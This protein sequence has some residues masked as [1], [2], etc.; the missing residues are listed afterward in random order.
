M[1][2]YPDHATLVIEI[3]M[4]KTPKTVLDFL[5]VAFCIF[6]IVKGFERMKRKD[7]KA[8]TAGPTPTE[9]LLT[10]IRDELKR[11]P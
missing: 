1:L 11:R 5:I 2:G 3:K 10:E 4:A 7:D 9:V 6:M 8:A